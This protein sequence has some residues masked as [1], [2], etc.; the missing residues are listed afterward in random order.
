MYARKGFVYIIEIK[1]CDGLQL[2]DGNSFL[3]QIYYV[4][5]KLPINLVIS[6]VDRHS[7]QFIHV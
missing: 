7:V 6:K 4:Q 3:R 1:L 2:I 5:V